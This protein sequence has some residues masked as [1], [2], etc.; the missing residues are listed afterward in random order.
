MGRL[1][2]K[3]VRSAVPDNAAGG[4]DWLICLIWFGTAHMRAI[5][6]NVGTVRMITM[7]IT[8]KPLLP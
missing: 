6:G 2:I 8:V 7:V 4:A 3:L 5:I 1:H